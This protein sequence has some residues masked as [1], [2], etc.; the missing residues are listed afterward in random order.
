VKGISRVDT[1]IL[2]RGEPDRGTALTA[3][4]AAAMSKPYL[5][6]NLADRPSVDAVRAWL[7][8]QG[9][10]I[11]NVAGPRESSQPGIHAE[12]VRF[13]REL[14]AAAAGQPA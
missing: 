13:L 8:A 6:V 4:L 5:V 2:T 14:L 12:A 7:E 1:L 3:E 9:V 11:L 10:R